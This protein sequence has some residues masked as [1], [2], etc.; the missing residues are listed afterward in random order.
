MR[1]EHT[2]MDATAANDQSHTLHHSQGEPLRT[3]H[4]RLL[5]E[6]QL[7]GD[8]EVSQN[9]ETSAIHDLA[10]RVIFAHSGLLTFMAIARVR[11]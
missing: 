6:H 7:L 5:I 1:G 9:R 10:H 11:V 2:G 4:I 8:D 3:G